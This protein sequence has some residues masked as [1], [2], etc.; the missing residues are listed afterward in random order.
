M[1]NRDNTWMYYYNNSWNNIGDSDTTKIY[2]WLSRITALKEVVNQFI[3]NTATSSSE[4][5]ID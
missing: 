1:I 3:R 2:E 4:S 5:N